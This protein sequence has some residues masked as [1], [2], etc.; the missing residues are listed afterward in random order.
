MNYTNAQLK[1]LDLAIKLGQ[2]SGVSPVMIR[3]G[4]AVLMA[5][6]GL[7]HN[8]LLV[9]KGGSRDR[10]VCQW[11]S[12][13]WPQITDECAFNPECAIKLFWPIFVKHPTWWIAYK[14][15]SWR[16]FYGKET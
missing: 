13:W 2:E 7:N 9:N 11:N 12:R 4:C 16:K 5:E 6:S 1:M 8:A 10:G 3:I 14:N 15:G